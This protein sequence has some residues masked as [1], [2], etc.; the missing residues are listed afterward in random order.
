MITG[1]VLSLWWSKQARKLQ[2]ANTNVDADADDDDNTADDGGGNGG[3]HVIKK[4]IKG[5][6]KSH[7]WDMQ[8]T[9]PL[10]FNQ[11]Q[12]QITH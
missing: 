2:Y 4:S 9:H 1:V 11:L 12:G 10:L 5:L 7:P 6:I 8:A 3:E